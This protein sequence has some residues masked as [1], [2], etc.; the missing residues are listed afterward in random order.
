LND[1]GGGAPDISVT[2]KSAL[3]GFLSERWGERTCTQSF[4]DTSLPDTAPGEV[5]S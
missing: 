2:S 5:A 3:Y 4:R 1:E